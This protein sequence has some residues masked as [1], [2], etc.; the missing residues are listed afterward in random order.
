MAEWSGFFD[1]HKVGESW[2]RVYLAEDFAKF[3]SPLIGNGVFAGRSNELQVFQSVPAG[4][5][6]TVSSG[7]SWIEGYGYL[8]D[9]DLM[10]FV[11]P[12]D[13]ALGRID[14][15]VNQWS[16]V[17]RQI[18]TVWKKG[19]PAVNP[20]APSLQWDA[21]YKELNLCTLN[22]TAGL[23][24]I[25]Q[26]KIK[27]TR[28]D[29]SV[30]GWVT[31]LI[32]QVDTSTLFAQ[33]DAAYE[34][35][36]ADTEDYLEAQKAAW[37][38]FFESVT[39]DLIIPVPSLEDVGKIPE[40]TP[41]GDGYRLVSFDELLTKHRSQV[42]VTL[43]ASDGSSMAGRTVTVTNTEDGSLFAEAVYDG[44]PVTLLIPIAVKYRVSVSA[45]SGYL[46][47]APVEYT[48]VAGVPR[49]INMYYQYGIRYGFRR[50]KNNSSPT[51][52]IEYLFDA[53]GK[54]PVSMNLSTNVFDYGD[55]EEFVRT[56]ARPVMLTYEGTVDYE[57]DP[58]DQTKKL[59][60]SSSDVSN[61][62]Y[63]GNA[64]V[65]FGSEFKWV[66]RYQDSSYEYVIF[67]NVQFDSGYAA[68]AHTGEDGNV[69]DAF[70][71][72]MFKGTNVS[73]KLR[74]IGTGSVMVSQ[75]RNT[76]VTYALNNGEGH[77]TIYK[78][79]WDYIGDLLTLIAKSDNSQAV[80]G[81]GRSASGNTA[82]IAVG[83]LKAKGPFWGSSNGTS[84]VKVF[85]IEGFW[86]NIW[87]G[88][89]GLILDWPNG[90][91]TKMTPPYSFNAAGY[92]AT[93]VVPSVPSVPSGT[94]GGYVD[95]A[96]VT[97]ESG[98]VPKTANGSETTY[99]CDGLWFNT[100]K[101]GYALVGG[102]WHHAGWCGSRCVD[103][104]ALASDAGP[105]AGSRLSFLPV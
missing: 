15:I 39:Q 67:S 30:C 4:M 99:Y 33:W 36:F 1:A 83:S 37:E 26:D 16:A 11:D 51:A 55:W 12:A 69:R 40:V 38:A 63:A 92:T 2:D 43:S 7:Q 31:G 98:Y 6:V 94:S 46:T 101:T 104:S 20:V 82:A 14:R 52:R 58:E 25:T 97:K 8:N 90:I 17:D 73:S 35:A 57:L 22:I 88:M 49:T 45:V 59:D 32:D 24:A 48:A 105:S 34:K 65:E 102:G 80:F 41:E 85:W 13:G 19:T 79:G 96:S 27:D 72:G 64:M 103:L 47:P 53:V 66:K 78:S 61:T 74:S 9:S 75:N 86:G 76:E 60:G 54:T 77:Y 95:T 44:Q 71:W 56:V 81:S 89:A 91:K 23:S 5:S 3:F 29:S 10:V 87:E 21:D 50:A 93:G 62:R 42:T 28:A 70:Y 18:R 68:Q 84:D 100:S